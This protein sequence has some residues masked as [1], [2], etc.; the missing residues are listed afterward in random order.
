VT[1]CRGCKRSMR[2]VPIVMLHDQDEKKRFEAV[3]AAELEAT[4]T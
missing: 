3:F 2:V 1:V 4:T